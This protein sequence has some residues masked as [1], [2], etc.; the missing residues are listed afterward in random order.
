M[1]NNSLRRPPALL[2]TILF[3]SSAVAVAGAGG[4]TPG[5]KPIEIE[6]LVIPGGV[7]AKN[8]PD[9]NSRGAKL[10][11]LF[12]SQ[13]HNLPNPKM[14]STVEW[15]ERFGRMMHHAS[16]MAMI[17]DFK[18]PSNN[19][20]GQIVRYLQD[21]GMKSLAT[22]DPSLKDPGAFEFIWYCSSCHNL[23]D[24]GQH[25]LAEWDALLSRMAQYRRDYGRPDMSLKDRKVILKFFAES[26]K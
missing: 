20:K 21:H 17:P 22:D 16:A 6:K 8:L 23:P 9:S 7:V 5:G 12:C 18:I 13:C 3:L 26:L 24:P 4:F 25:T 19:Q 15:P 2:V 10:L 14:Y 1:R 11:A